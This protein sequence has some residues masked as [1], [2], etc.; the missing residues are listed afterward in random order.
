[1][2]NWQDR[3]G[4]TLKAALERQEALVS[5]AQRSVSLGGDVLEKFAGFQL[6]VATDS[7]DAAVRQVKLLGQ[8][9]GVT[10]YV[11]QQVELASD[12]AQ[13]ARARA[14]EFGELLSETAA[15][16]AGLFAVTAPGSGGSARSRK[17]A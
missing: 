1:M 11:R 8:P 9:G 6:G 10:T 17:A 7:V 12:S 13:T 4:G 5:G 16:A 3:I 15:D 2:A 14:G